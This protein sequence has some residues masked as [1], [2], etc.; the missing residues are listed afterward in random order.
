MTNKTS[1]FT[2]T[3]AVLLCALMV[4]TMIPLAAFAA[5]YK[6][7]YYAAST[8]SYISSVILY[9]S[10]SS[11]S[12]AE[13]NLRNR[14]YTPVGKNFNAGDG[15]D[16]KYIHMGA[17]FTTDPT[18]AIRAFGIYDGGSRPNTYTPTVN[19]STVT[20]YKV[21]AGIVDWLPA[22]GDGVVDL[23]KGGGGND[24]TIYATRDP[25]AG[26]PVT[27]FWM[28]QNGN[29][30][31]SRNQIYNG[32][33]TMVVDQNGS[34]QDVNE[35]SGGDYVY[36]GYKSTA[37]SV[38]TTS[39]RST[40]NTSAQYVD[41]NKYTQSSVNSLSAARAN[42]KT[43]YDNF[44]N[45][46]GV[47]TYTQTQINSYQSAITTAQNNLCVNVY[48]NANGGS[49]SG[50]SSPISIKT[51]TS[52]KGNVVLANYTAT[53]SGWNF[54]GW[55]TDQ[56]ATVG[57]KATTMTNYNTTYYAV[58]S[59][60][61]IA[62]YYYF[63]TDGTIN[64]ETQQRSL[65]NGQNSATFSC[66]QRKDVTINGIT[67]KF[68]GYREDTVP[69][70]PTWTSGTKTILESSG[71]THVNYYAVYKRDVQFNQDAGKGSPAVAGQ[72]AVQY[73]ASTAAKPMST[74]TFTVSADT[75]SYE[76]G[77]FKGWDDDADAATVKYT[78]GSTISVSTAKNVTLYA[79]YDLQTYTVTFKAEDGTVIKTET[80]RH[81]YD[82]HV[83]EAP[84]KSP[85]RDHE[86]VF[87]GWTGYQEITRDTEITAT[88]NPVDHNYVLFEKALPDCT[89]DGADVYKCDKCGMFKEEVLEKLGH[90]I[91][92]A[93]G[94]EATCER[95]G[96]TDYVFCSRCSKTFQEAEK[97]PALGHTWQFVETVAPTCSTKGYDLYVCSRD[98]GHTKQENIVAANSTHTPKTIPA[99][100][101][102]CTENGKTEG[103]IC[104]LCS[105]IL[106]SPKAV[107]TPGHTVVVTP[108]VAP[109]CT[110]EG[111]TEGKTCS[112]CGAVLK[113]VETIPALG[114]VA[115]DVEYVAPTC[116][117]T[118]LTE[119]TKC[120]LCGE[121][122]TGCQTIPVLS[123]EYS[124]YKTVEAKCETAGY[125]T[126]RC[127]LCGDTYN[128]DE[129]AATGH[130][131][132]EIA[133]IAPTCSSLGYTAG[134][135][136]SVCNKVLVKPTT[137]AK[138]SHDKVEYGAVAPTFT[139]D[140]IKA[141]IKCSMCGRIYSEPS[142]A[143]A[144]GHTADLGTMTQAATCI[145]EGE[146]TYKCVDCG[147]ILEVKST[148]FGGHKLG[149]EY[150]LEGGN[151]RFTCEICGTEI[152]C[153]P[154]EVGLPD[155]GCEKCG[156]HHQASSVLFKYNGFYCKLVGFFRSIL[157]KFQGK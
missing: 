112:T 22:E 127:A 148:G 4:A 55:S 78:A 118:G 105:A 89:K 110:E 136:C 92:T 75:P 117:S 49:L 81:G 144:K 102:T 128:T 65:T 133:A 11:N 82:A 157:A 17:K 46:T 135:Q 88:Y 116:T 68:A 77:I 69:T 134:S 71:I 90:Q 137:V 64:C 25:N 61:I 109:T 122:L 139:E 120:V 1:R 126:Y 95:D 83:P 23:N 10:N 7:E 156:L 141:G 6:N 138:L 37:V 32:G 119:G 115:T 40:Y 41:M 43:V 79:V 106:V 39:L 33:Y 100:E 97:I 15:N 149:E 18:Q 54:I 5:Q 2:K 76:G 80:V 19:G 29:G 125:T 153:N 140:G 91:S 60:D 52:A 94:Y 67:Y 152:E 98:T 12:D 104:A 47:G 51:G 31:T 58:Y 113:A 56:A 63:D 21:G 57:S 151:V 85:D 38:S 70:A 9:Y 108:A 73:L 146:I 62:D 93:P 145:T 101:A 28:S 3:L 30:E 27:E 124:V 44:D 8:T 36:C 123:H 84:A 154:S 114:H 45:R 111:S 130:T 155:T 42:A 96:I 59:K 103:S 48:F 99:V 107:I 20:M 131:E 142:V 150:T 74:V 34:A 66:K 72:T 50:F 24:L 16:S 143:P 87:A 147:E 26:P 14:G 121:Y 13:N 86:Y 129:V 132:V 35:G 53:K